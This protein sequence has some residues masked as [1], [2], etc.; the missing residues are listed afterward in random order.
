MQPYHY[1]VA[2]GHYARR[3][4]AARPDSARARRAARPQPVALLFALWARAA[5]P[6]AHEAVVFVR[7]D[8]LAGVVDND[9]RRRQL[10]CE[11][12]SVG[13]IAKQL[14]AGGGYR[15]LKPAFAE[16]D[17]T[18][19]AE[20]EHANKLAA[21]AHVPQVS[22]QPTA[23]AN[24]DGDGD[25][26]DGEKRR[27]ALEAAG[28]QLSDVAA[29]LAFVMELPKDKISSIKY[30]GRGSKPVQLAADFVAAHGWDAFKRTLQRVRADKSP[31]KP[32]DLKWLFAERNAEYLARFTGPA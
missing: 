19:R 7:G 22:K 17:A 10:L 18:A 25:G 28:K 21:L 20:I 15:L 13:A 9:V 2:V 11:L 1:A 24:V 8:F 14:V 31:D 23:S 6:F 27:L 12:R 16:L 4:A 3:L 29:G 32:S 26:S 30:S 5:D